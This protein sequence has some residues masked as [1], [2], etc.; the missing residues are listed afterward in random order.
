[1]FVA[2][3]IRQ[4]PLVEQDLFALPEHM[5]SPSG[6]SGIRVAQALVFF[7][8]FCRTLSVLLSFFFV[9]PS[10]PLYAIWL[11]PLWLLRF[12]SLMAIMAKVLVVL[13]FVASIEVNGDVYSLYQD[14]CT[15]CWK[16]V[17]FQVLHFRPQNWSLR[18]NWSGIKHLNAIDHLN[19]FSY[20]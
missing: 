8:M 1:M 10:S 15:R 6:F 14:F 16:S 9:C 2:R 3:I 5:S 13:R 7:V 18:Y 20:R 12:A 11:P 17:V 19:D 4:R